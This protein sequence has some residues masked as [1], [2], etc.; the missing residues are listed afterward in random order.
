MSEVNLPEGW[1]LST[2]PKSIAIDGLISDGDWVESKDQDPNGSVRLIQLADIGD[3]DFKNKSKRLMSPERADALN[4]T[5]LQSG[6]VLIARMP[7]PLGR[8]CIFPGVGQDAVTVVDICLI[9]TGKKTAIS[10]KILTYWINSPSIRGLISANASGT[11]RTRI[12]R[13]KLELFE[14]PIPPLAEQKAIADKLDTLLTQVET[15]K[16]RLKRI[17]EILKTF[18]QS[19][20]AS[21]VSGKL[22][23]SNCNTWQLEKLLTLTTKIGSGATPKGG[24]TTYKESGIPLVRSLNIHTYFI[25]YEDLAFIDEKQANK[26]ANVEIEEN[27]V[28]LNITGASIGRVNI[29]PKDFV[30]GRVNQHVAIIRCIQEKLIPKYLYIY[31]ASPCIQ[32]WIEKENYGATRQALTKGMIEQIQIT[33]PP[34]EEQTEIVRR[35]EELFAFADS[36]EQK[37][38]AALAQVNNLTQ[39]ILAKAFRG[40]L[41]ADWRAANP[42]FISGDN[43]AKALLEKIKAEREAIEKQPKPKRSAIKKKTGSHM[44]KQ[45]MKVVEALKQAGEP[46]SGQQLLAAAGYPSDSNTEQLEQFFLDI[47]DALTIEESIVKLERSDDS[48][49]WFALANPPINKA[50]N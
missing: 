9:R 30:G 38:N 3:G 6:D 21:A 43:S 1:T 17:P 14:F 23:N 8:A 29:A 46:L 48:Q 4:C 42:E 13:K 32:K 50:K 34:L 5:Y 20:L 11:T 7:E 28:L 49:D 10:N 31:L 36:I 15:T 33:L 41:T 19:V 2:L 24:K 45:I 35:V 44:S 37:T 40:E 26:L 16:S 27:D 18:L 22:I 47:R 12:T 25:K 39:S